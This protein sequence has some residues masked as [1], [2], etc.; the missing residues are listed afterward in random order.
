MVGAVFASIFAQLAWWPWAFWTQAFACVGLAVAAYLVVP[1]VPKG[2]ETKREKGDLDIE[3]SITGVAGLVLFNFAWNQGPLVGFRTG[4]VIA[5]LVLGCFFIA[6]FFYIE[7]HRASHPLVPLKLFSGETG[8]VLACISVGWSSFGIWL[9]YLWQHMEVLRGLT[10]LHAV[11]WFSPIALS[12]ACAAITTGFILCLMQPAYVML[13]AM[14]AFMTGNI[15]V[16]TLPVHQIY[17]A[18]IF[19]ACIIMPW[20]MVSCIPPHLSILAGEIEK[21]KIKC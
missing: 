19:V 8:F 2:Q 21:N 14:S 9:Y 6:L 17:W 13:I 5:T 1:S 4:Y 11:A 15:L 16:A 7:I 20:G 3:G 18:Q 10:P 12:G